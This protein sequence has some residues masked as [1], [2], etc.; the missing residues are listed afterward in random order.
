MPVTIASLRWA[1][2]ALAAAL[3]ACA[4]NRRLAPFQ[5]TWPIQPRPEYRVWW[6][7]TEAC[8]GRDA[9]FAAVQFFAVTP[10]DGYIYLAGQRA[11]AWWVRRGNRIYLPA[12]RLDDEQLVRHEMLHAITGEAEHRPD[13]FVRRCHVASAETWADSSLQ[14]DPENPQ[15]R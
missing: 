8:S 3:V 6:A 14:W 15:G 13:E 4:G 10:A 9:N 11:H 5:P 12:N 7:R 1:A 2:L